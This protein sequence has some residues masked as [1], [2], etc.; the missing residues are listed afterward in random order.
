MLKPAM[1]PG[2]SKLLITDAVIPDTEASLLHTTLDLAMMEMAAE[3]KS[4]E[5]FRQILQDEGFTVQKVWRSVKG[6]DS[7]FEAED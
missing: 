5:V 6:V 4:E 3:E 7:M 2:Y 1:I